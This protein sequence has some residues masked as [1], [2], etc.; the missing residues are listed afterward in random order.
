[1]EQICIVAK[2]TDCDQAQ[3]GAGMIARVGDKAREGVPTCTIAGSML[4]AIGGC[5]VG[6]GI[7]AVPGIG[8]VVTVVTSG[9][10]LA[11]TLLGAGIGMGSGSL[12]EILANLG[13]TKY[14]ARVCSDRFSEGEYLV[15]VNGTD[16][17][18]LSAESIFSK[19]CSSK[20]WV[21]VY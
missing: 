14:R 20:V 17:E 18:V 3:G 7:L 10:A 1:M 2:D 19:S 9:T 12:I 5:L 16:G 11:A 8:L 21:W 4:G 15:I 6:L 13:M